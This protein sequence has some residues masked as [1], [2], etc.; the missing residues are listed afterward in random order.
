MK[1]N[2]FL[3][4]IEIPVSDFVLSALSEYSMVDIF[5]THSLPLTTR[6]RAYVVSSI[7]DFKD[8]ISKSFLPWYKNGKGANDPD[9]ENYTVE[10]RTLTLTNPELEDFTERLSSGVL[11]TT[12]YH[13]GLDVRL[14]LDCCKRSC[15][16][17]NKI[18]NSLGFPQITVIECYGPE[19]ANSFPIDFGHLVR[20][21]G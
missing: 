12:A 21:F 3:D 2:N 4:E 18:N 11:V 15:A 8:R 5:W 7:E 6:A 20:K 19:V 9:A 13:I 10:D 1:S 14:I 17:Q 16:I